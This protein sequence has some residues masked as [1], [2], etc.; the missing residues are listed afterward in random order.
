MSSTSPPEMTYA[1]AA[2]GLPASGSGSLARLG[3]RFVGVLVDWLV[4]QLVVFVVAR[5]AFGAAGAAS[6]LPLAVFA[7]LTVLSLSVVAATFGHYV[8]G[9]QLRQVRPGTW[10]LQALIRTLL[11]C[12]F[13]PAVLTAKDGRGLHDV[14]AG[15]V[16][17][18][19]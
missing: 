6:F 9:L 5:D 4:A 2:L 14:A 1:G 15:T 10:P 8:M 13:L 11:L 19:R 7:V 18:R 17:V 3:R 16:L 12:L